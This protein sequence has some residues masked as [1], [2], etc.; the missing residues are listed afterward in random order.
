VGQVIPREKIEQI[1]SDLRKSNQK[2]VTTN[3]CFDILHVGHV[4]YLRKTAE[5]A[6]VLIIALNSDSSVHRLKGHTRPVNPEQDR[7]EIL[8]ALEFVDYVVIFEED[9]PVN[10]LSIIKPDFHAK[11]GDYDINTLPET[12]VIEENGGKVVF[13]PFVEG[14]STTNIIAR[15]KV[16]K[17]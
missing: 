7:A 11:G 5:L 8:A 14:K 6:D 4:R 9:T 2:I 12:G 13:I 15:A 10:L 17:S 16:I 1:V 3:G